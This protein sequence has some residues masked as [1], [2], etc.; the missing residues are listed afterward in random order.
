MALGNESERRKQRVLMALSIFLGVAASVFVG[1]VLKLN[2][3]WTIS[4]ALIILV[5]LLW[6]MYVLAKQFEEDS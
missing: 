6:A 3:F 4:I 1:L 5:L 2:L